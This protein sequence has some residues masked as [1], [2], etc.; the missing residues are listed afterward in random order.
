MS[1][2]DTDC[3]T[4]P[5]TVRNGALAEWSSVTSRHKKI[6]FDSAKN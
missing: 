1:W 3:G 5:A 2:S 6:L 4:Y